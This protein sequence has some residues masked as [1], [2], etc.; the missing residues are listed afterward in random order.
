MRRWWS[1]TS[2]RVRLTTWYS[3]AL[4]LMR[5]VYAA[6]TYVAVRHEFYEQLEVETHADARDEMP[7][8]EARIEQ[9]LG[10]VLLV[11]VV[12][13]PLIVGLAG[14]GGYVLARDVWKEPRRA[15]PLDNVIDVQMTRLRRK[16]DIEGAARLIH[17][18]RG[19]GFVVREGEP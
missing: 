5:I 2:I 7:D 9:Q 12:G 16:V 15:T 19:V 4:T 11:L 18:V 8:G 6:A 14:V 1:R 17:T 10:E 13:L 3:A